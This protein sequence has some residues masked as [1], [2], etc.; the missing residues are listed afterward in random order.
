MSAEEET[1]SPP[2]SLTL[3]PAAMTGVT[4]PVEDTELVLALGEEIPRDTAVLENR[5]HTHT[6]GYTH[7][8]TDKHTGKRRTCYLVSC[9][10]K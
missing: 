7:T 3:P 9:K 5:G 6:H 4:S 10:T 1:S 2:P 8:R